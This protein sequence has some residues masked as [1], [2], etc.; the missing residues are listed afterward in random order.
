MGS[1]TERSKLVLKDTQSSRA[2]D[3]DTPAQRRSAL[4]HTLLAHRSETVAASRDRVSLLRGG[5]ATGAAVCPGSPPTRP[6]CSPAEM[7]V[8]C[9]HRK[10][11]RV[12]PEHCKSAQLKGAGRQRRASP[13]QAQPQAWGLG[14][15]SGPREGPVVCVWGV[16]G[17]LRNP[18]LQPAQLE[19]VI[20]S[21]GGGRTEEPRKPEHLAWL[22]GQPGDASNPRAHPT[23]DS[24]EPWEIWVQVPA[25]V[26][27]SP[28]LPSPASSLRWLK[29]A[30]SHRSM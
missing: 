5:K 6:A 7:E 11:I 9:H 12:S 26:P 30:H 16:G 25:G 4:G 10:T 21:A 14:L 1:V 3:V 18:M 15:T 20:L 24:A 8:C 28:H 17:T 2:T 19:H 29:Q 22:C 13:A 27:S 23:L